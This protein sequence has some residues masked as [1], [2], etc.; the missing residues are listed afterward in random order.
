MPFSDE[1]RASWASSRSC[2]LLLTPRPTPERGVEPVGVWA[3]CSLLDYTEWAERG[4]GID[5]GDYVTCLPHLVHLPS[6]N[7]SVVLDSISSISGSASS[8]SPLW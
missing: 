2:M 6:C 8:I 7:T 1:S 3:A 5:R 4:T